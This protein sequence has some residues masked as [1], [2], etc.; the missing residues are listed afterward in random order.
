[1][2]IRHDWAL[3]EVR[4][5]HDLPLLELVHRAQT[6]HREAFH[7][8]KVQLCSLLSIKTGGCPE[9]CAYCPQAA[10]YHTFVPAG[11]LMETSDALA[12]APGAREAGGPRVGVGPARRGV[13]AGP[14]FDRALEV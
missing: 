11:P 6:V 12:A 8:N 7:D 13:K 10:R 14:P 1:M 2:Y 5:L 4:A 9:D 3:P